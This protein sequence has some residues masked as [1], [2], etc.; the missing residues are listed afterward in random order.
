ME[1][2]KETY[3]KYLSGEGCK[4]KSLMSVKVKL[5]ATREPRYKKREMV[6]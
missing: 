4:G 5:K 1:R 3:S 2:H 6:M